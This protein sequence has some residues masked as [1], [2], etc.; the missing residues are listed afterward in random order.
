MADDNGIRARVRSQMAAL[1]LAGAEGIERAVFNNAIRRCKFNAT[2]CCWAN[3]AFSECYKSSALA[4]LR[5]PEA[6][7]ESI[8]A[9]AS[10]AD[11]VMKTP[12][13]MRPDIW[14]EI[15]RAK[16]ERDSAYGAKPA[17]NT[18]MYRCRKCQSRECHYFGLQ[19]RSGDEPMTIFVT[20]LNCGNRWRTEG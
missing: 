7:A 9:G 15:L 13:E 16:K 11:T 20:C 12:Q 14:G 1:G 10:E 8:A 19:T 3:V 4:V 5:N 18:S 6:V 17:A 2:P